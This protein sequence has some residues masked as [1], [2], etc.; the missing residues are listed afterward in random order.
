MAR[1]HYW[2]GFA[3]GAAAGAGAG[4]GVMLAWKGLSRVR[5]GRV[6]RLEKSLQIGRAPEQV[7]RTWAD[8]ESL[9]R[10]V[11]FIES[12]E[13]RGNY[14]HWVVNL[15]GRRVEWD[16]EITQ[17]IPQ[18]ALGWK[19]ISGPKHT[20]RIDFS[21][22]GNDT[23]VHVTM[24]Y[25]PPFQLG[26]LFSPVGE[27]AEH[28]IERALR[29]FK[30]AL[31]GKGQEDVFEKARF[32]PSAVGEGN[33]GERAT[34]TYGNTGSSTSPTAAEAELRQTQQNRYGGPETSV[35][36]HRPPESRS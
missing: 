2:N 13:R 31:E 21:P 33:I 29:S 22:I 4:I 26:R 8:L 23:L 5:A 36:F 10:Y 9:P 17:E 14:T 1:R 6:V 25:A 7:F 24:N 16:A 12:V 27:P 11:D 34:G 19:S 20:G 30:A 35:E 3:A 15:A 18:E 32:A 28:Y